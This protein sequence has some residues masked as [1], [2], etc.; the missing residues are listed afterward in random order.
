MAGTCQE[1]MALVSNKF[2]S[3]FVR[4]AYLMFE[5]IFLHILLDPLNLGKLLCGEDDDRKLF[6]QTIEIFNGRMSM[7]ACVGYVVQ[8]F[9]TGE[10]WLLTC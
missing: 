7:L 8:E 2:L 3:Y 1:I 9:V 4:Y 5:Y 10:D 6:V